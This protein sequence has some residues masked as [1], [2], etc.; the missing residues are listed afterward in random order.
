[1]SVPAAAV[2]DGLIEK[3]SETALE[4]ICR[5]ALRAIGEAAA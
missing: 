5:D 1:M 3:T 2:Q 4:T